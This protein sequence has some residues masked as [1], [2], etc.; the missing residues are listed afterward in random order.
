[1]YIPQILQIS[2]DSTFNFGSKQKSWRVKGRLLAPVCRYHGCKYSPI[3]LCSKCGNLKQHFLG[4]KKFSVFGDPHFLKV[5]SLMKLARMEK[6]VGVQH[7]FPQSKL[8]DGHPCPLPLAASSVS[9][10]QNI[11]NQW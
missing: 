1:M 2:S 8:E 4:F 9:G 10:R 6:H 5:E 7:F 11:Q 3:E